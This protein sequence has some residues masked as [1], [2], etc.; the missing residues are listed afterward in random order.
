MIACC[1]CLHKVSVKFPEV[2]SS[3]RV[4][5]SFLFDMI[6]RP[7]IVIY[8]LLYNQI[9][10]Y[11]RRRFKNSSLYFC[12]KIFTI[13]L[14]E[15]LHYIF[16]LSSKVQRCV[17][18]HIIASCNCT[19]LKEPFTHKFLALSNTVMNKLSSIIIKPQLFKGS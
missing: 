5:L 19:F 4:V 6:L 1:L 13:F 11:L 14:Q 16:A 12:R 8:S 17:H 10:S 3:F 9:R 2:P 15:T 7:H 18:G